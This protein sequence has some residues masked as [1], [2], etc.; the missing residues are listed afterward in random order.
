MNKAQFI[1]Q[2]A[3]PT[4][5]RKF[6]ASIDF[7]W[8]AWTEA[9][10]LDQWWAPSPWQSKTKEMTFEPNGKRLY[11]M[12]GPEGEEHWGLTTYL[13]IDK[14]KMFSGTD[15]FCDNS[16]QVNNELPEATF[17]NQF[18]D[19]DE[20]TTVTVITEYASEEHLEQVIQMGMKEGL[21][22]AFENLDQV[23][24]KLNSQ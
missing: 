19:G 13:S 14:H 23:L 17:V 3:K 1:A 12:V 8:R 20:T 2:G 5:T 10:L 22:M 11:A 4:V 9:D 15:A 16:G 18:K 6:D 7:V 21:E 24:E